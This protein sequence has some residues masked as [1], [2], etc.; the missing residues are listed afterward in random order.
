M[1]ELHAQI[2]VLE[3]KLSQSLVGAS[4][5]LTERTFA[6]LRL[7]RSDGT[8]GQGEASPLPGYSLDSIDEV[9][10]ELQ[11]LADGPIRVDP[12]AGPLEI[13]T[14]SFAEHPL[15]HPAS[16][17]AFETA[18]LDWL[19]QT[20]GEPLHRLLGGDAERQRIPIADL[21]MDPDPS[22]WPERADALISDGATHLKLKIGPNLDTELGALRRIREAHP[23]VALRLDGN[24]R[25]SIDA[26][27]KHGSALESLELELVEEPV[28][29]SDWI[30][31]LSLPLPFALDETLRDPGSTERLLGTGK[32]RAI[33]IKP[34]VIGGL[35]AAFAAA[36][37]AASHGAKYLV[38]HTFDGPIGRAVAAELALALQT[39]LA[40]GLGAHPALALWPRH[41]IAAIEGR[42][43]VPH[44]APGLGLQFEELAD[45]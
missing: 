42:E 17:L 35:R 15:A 4:A 34:M 27:R 5:G 40:A 38:S 33:V 31:A 12:L 39:E 1:I 18:L 29:P 10:G 7:M 19:G 41:R 26:L 20:R 28:A 44:D 14:E 30:A 11:H 8:G 2:D 22:R 32:I 37:H 3:G 13:L 45:E 43:V 23:N 36:E 6:V 21:V 25:I 24:Q 9:A 16:R